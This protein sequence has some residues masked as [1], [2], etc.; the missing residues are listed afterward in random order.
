MSYLLEGV[1][2]KAVVSE[3]GHT[4]VD[5]DTSSKLFEEYRPR[6]CAG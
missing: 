3:Y 5:V 2:K 6:P 1:V 4:E